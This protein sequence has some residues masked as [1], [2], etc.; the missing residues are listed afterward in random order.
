MH[1]LALVSGFRDPNDGIYRTQAKSE[2][3]GS[4]Q[5][6]SLL[7]RLHE[8]A[9]AEWLN[10]GLEQQKA[11]L[12]LYFCGL[13]SGNATARTWLRLES[14]R[15]LLPESAHPVAR[16]L[17]IADLEPLLHLVAQR[18][19]A[20]RTIVERH[21]P[22]EAFLTT[23]QLAKWLGVSPRSLRLWAESNQIPAVKIGRHWRFPR[24]GVR[25]WILNR[26]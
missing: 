16:H 18:P 15:S 3:A 13:I 20:S 2:G 8:E 7:R 17:F 23:E 5:V 12:E 1:R 11:D 14:Y 9:F 19:P 24:Q 26:A 21:L 10:Y 6:D 22:D 25:N 4:P